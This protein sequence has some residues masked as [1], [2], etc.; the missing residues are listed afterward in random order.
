MNLYPTP[1]H[2]HAAEAIVEFFATIPEVE[3]VCLICSCARSKASK[4]SCLD[5]LALGNPKL[6][7]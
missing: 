1:E 3:T 7:P 4:D 5:I 6:C 2:Q